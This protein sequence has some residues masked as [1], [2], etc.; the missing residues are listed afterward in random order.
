[1][2]LDVGRD[3][4]LVGVGFRICYRTVG[5][6]GA[7]HLGSLTVLLQFLVPICGPPL[8][9]V[10]SGP[11]LYRPSFDGFGVIGP[12]F[13]QPF[14]RPLVGCTSHIMPY[15]ACIFNIFDI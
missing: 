4:D 9:V 12:S 11:L 7:D 14:L 6:E 1:M 5:I 8:D 15:M 3:L 13:G 2:V 10:G